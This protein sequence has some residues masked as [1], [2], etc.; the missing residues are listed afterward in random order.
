M[1]STLAKVGFGFLLVSS[2]A[3]VGIEIKN[4]TLPSDLGS[5]ITYNV[6]GV[7]WRGR[8]VVE[9]EPRV[10]GFSFG[11]SGQFTMPLGSQAILQFSSLGLTHYAYP[12]IPQGATWSS[13]VSSP[14]GSNDAGC[15]SF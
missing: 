3:C 5:G 8:T 2:I 11:T 7:N 4:E 12:R 10:G 13:W 9:F 1:F 15:A 6:G 14:V